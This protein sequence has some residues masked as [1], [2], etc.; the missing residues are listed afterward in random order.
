[1]KL[2]IATVLFVVAA[3]GA[4]GQTEIDFQGSLKSNGLP[5][6]GS[7]D[8]A[9]RLY[10]SATGGA[11]IGPTVT[12]NGVGV[13]NGLFRASLDFGAVFDG[14]ARWLQIEVSGTTLSPRIKLANAPTALFSSRSPWSGLSGIPSGFADGIDDIGMAG[15][16]LRLVG[17]TFSIETSGALAG[18]SLTFDGARL[19]W[20]HPTASRLLLPYSGGYSGASTAFSIT[21]QGAGRAALFQ[22]DNP[23][24]SN[25][26]VHVLSNGTGWGLRVQMTNAA[27][28]S[29][30]VFAYT[31]GAD[32]AGLFQIDNSSNSAAALHAYTNG[33]GYAAYFESLNAASANPAMVV[34]TLG[35]G[36]AAEFIGGIKTSRIQLTLSPSAGYVLTSDSVGNGTWQPAQSYTAGAGLSLTGN[37]FSIANQGV[38]T[39]MLADGAV[40]IAKLNALGAG[41]GQAVTMTETGL[42]WGNPTAGE[43]RLPFFQSR[44]DIITLFAITNTGAG[45]AIGARAMGAG[46]AVYGVNDSGTFGSLGEPSYGVRGTDD[47]SQG[48]DGVRGESRNGVGVTG[49]STN[50]HGVV[51]VS[52]NNQGVLG[53]STDGHGVQ[54]NSATQF[55]VLGN[56][57]TSSGV[58]GISDFAAGVAALNLSSSNRGGLGLPDVGA[59]GRHQSTFNTGELGT[60]STGVNGRSENG[61]GVYGTSDN[62]LG[63]YGRHTASGNYGNL[64]TSM[65]GAYGFVAPADDDDAYFGAWGVSLGVNPEGAGV[66]ANGNGV[67]APGTPNAA[68]LRVHDGAVTVS[69]LL[70]NRFAGTIEVTTGWLPIVSCAY[71]CPDCTHAHTIGWYAD[72][73]L[74]NALIIPGPP[75]T[76]SIIQATVETVPGPPPPWTSYYVQVYAKMPGSCVLRITRMGFATTGGGCPA[77]IETNYIHYTIV[78]PIAEP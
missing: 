21:A 57:Q 71:A 18:Q 8:M 33:V 42:A 78:N 35:S 11:Q 61:V 24:N 77:P 74:G 58:Y 60:E 31:R 44:D 4:F 76:G 14:A 38:Q 69:G 75:Q 68:A 67:S 40:S 41:V 32:R 73:P 6:N 3:L 45:H 72:V 10:D 23:T 51:G 22:V 7:F 19:V 34:R 13:S 65:A 53:R 25:A 16:G 59:Y 20:S 36:P 48:G 28:S 47:T 64:G 63:V 30:A 26:A 27:N 29:P 46:S 66:R 5:A 37:S 39:N 55:G 2:A 52:R 62:Y 1:M 50:S 49:S 17:N 15:E 12:R 56:S 54:G 70:T 9:F 43:L